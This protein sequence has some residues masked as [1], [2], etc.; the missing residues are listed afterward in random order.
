M[1]FTEFPIPSV[2]LVSVAADARSAINAMENTNTAVNT[3]IATNAPNTIAALDTSNS[4]WDWI[5][6]KI[7]AITSIA[8]GGAWSFGGKVLV[9]AAQA[10]S[11]KLTV[12]D[13]TSDDAVRITQT[14]TGNAL[15]VEDT[16][17]PDASPFV[18]DN[19]GKVSTW[20]QITQRRA[21]NDA[22]A[23]TFELRK[24][25]GTSIAPTAVLNNDQLGNH[26]YA[27]YD[28]TSDIEGARVAASVDGTPGTNDMP[29][30]LKF[31][32]RPQ[33]G[34]AII[35]RMRITSGGKVGVGTTAPVSK[36]H[37]SDG[38]TDAAVTITQTGAGNVL[39]VEDSSA[40]D[41]T[42]FVIGNDGLVTTHSGIRQ[43]T[44][45]DV[46]SSNSLIGQKARGTPT[47]PLPITS[48]DNML[49]LAGRGYDGAIFKD[50]GYIFISSDGVPN[51]PATAISNATEYRINT[52]GTTDF[53]TF[54]AANNNVGTVFT[55]NRGG[56]AGDGDGTAIR[57]AGDMPGR[58]A[59]STA[60]DNGAGPTERMRISNS[61][62]VGI[63]TTSTPYRLNVL[64]KI[65]TDNNSVPTILI[66]TDTNNG[67]TIDT[68]RGANNNTHG[69][70]ISTSNGGAPTEK[71]RIQPSGNVGIGTTSI[72]SK[73]HINGDLSLSSATT[74]TTAIAGVNGDVPAQVVGYIQVNIN[75]T[76][77]KIPYYA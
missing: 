60:P 22:F 26:A 56:T 3:A 30:R 69:L 57:T 71:V 61:G 21:A 55:A 54:G 76:S 4:L 29:G 16:T 44:Y 27:G 6:G 49:T 11:A 24:Y 43:N 19:G 7:G 42:P 13:N 8:A 41:T 37:V 70:A 32:T 25:R 18:I 1:S 35:E 68:V 2:E 72:N 74:S 33:G 36:L 58:I 77:R 15:V 9:G 45:S 63:N 46:T 34:S 40:P 51:T 62:N 52:V 65:S 64:N 47:S 73:L 66:G 50:A 67:A 39:V 53:T 23:Q 38:S 31:F 12:T 10:T 48:G 75:G 17:N 20:S 28:G 5:V 59:F 14:G